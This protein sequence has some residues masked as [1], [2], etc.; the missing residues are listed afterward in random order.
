MRF[1]IS[2]SNLITGKAWSTRNAQNTCACAFSTYGPSARWSV[3]DEHGTGKTQQNQPRNTSQHGIEAQPAAPG[4]KEDALIECFNEF[5]DKERTDKNG[6]INL[7]KDE[8]Y[9]TK[10]F[11]AINT[12]GKDF[13]SAEALLAAA[14]RVLPEAKTMT[15][16]HAKE[17]INTLEHEMNLAGLKPNKDGNIDLQEFQKLAN[18]AASGMKSSL[19]QMQ[20]GQGA[21][22]ELGPEEQMHCGPEE[23]TKHYGPEEC[24]K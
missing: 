6:L 4:K 5:M 1:S 8:N 17:I 10:L 20:R 11:N 14:K 18:F 19:E 23:C 15:V 2:R 12:D 7:V 13:I 22:M 9:Q 3:G 24:T 16:A 21:Q